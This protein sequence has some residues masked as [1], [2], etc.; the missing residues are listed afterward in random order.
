MK[1]IVESS[2]AK[3]EAR[4]RPLEYSDIAMETVL[5]IRQV[6]YLQLCQT[7]GFMNSLARVMK[8]DITIA[9]QLYSWD[10]TY[11]GINYPWTVLLSLLSS[12]FSDESRGLEGV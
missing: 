10:I 4:D 12:I 2:P 5:F 1:A 7:E 11:S 8:A 3:T 9:D 6:F